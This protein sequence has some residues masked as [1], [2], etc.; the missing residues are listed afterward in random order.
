MR[1]HGGYYDGRVAVRREVTVS[2]DGDLLHLTGEGVGQSYPLGEVTVTP[3][4]G[5]ILRVLR[6]P[7]GGSCELPDHEFVAQLEQLQGRRGGRS[8]LHR[9]E[10]NLPMALG[11][12]LL[13]ALVL[14]LFLR[15]GVPVMAREVAFRVPPAVEASMGRE[16][17]AILDRLLLQPSRLDP[18]RRAELA[19]LFRRVAGG[20]AAGTGYRLEFRSSEKLGANAFALP[21]GIVVLTDGLVELAKSDDEIAAILAHEVG[22]LRQR[23]ILRHVLQNSVAGLLVATL[24]GDLTSIT[25]LSATLPTAIV[26][27]T[28]SRQ[29][30]READD[31]A[32]AWMKS[33]GVEPRRYAEVLARLQAQ[34]DTRSGETFEPKSPLRNYLSN[35]PDTGERIRRVL[36]SGGQAPVQ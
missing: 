2:L 35:H 13:I 3:G 16:T 29:F 4:V 31:A 20:G 14:L 22:H 34:L 30:E 26:D 10:K 8:L 11:T 15:F 5:S 6:L 1:A 24:T 7:D 28:F 32:V 9:W 36:A 33:A 23:H 25:S 27:A 19:K 17:M 21:G 12:L 18:G